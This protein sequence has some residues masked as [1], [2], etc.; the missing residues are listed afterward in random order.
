MTDSRSVL[1]TGYRSYLCLSRCG[2]AS[3]YPGLDLFEKAPFAFAPYSLKNQCWEPLQTIVEVA[4]AAFL[5]VYR[6]QC[7]N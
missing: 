2:Y 4:R 7:W 3:C 6:T 1:V 5:S